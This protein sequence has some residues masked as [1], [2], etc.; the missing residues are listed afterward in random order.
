MFEKGTSIIQGGTVV[1][2]DRLAPAHDVVIVDGR[3]S[4]IEPSRVRPLMPDIKLIDATGCYVAP[5]F[6]DIH[7]DYIEGIASPRPSVVMDLRG[8]LYEADRS[9]AAYGVT[10]IYHSLSIYK[11]LVFDHKPIRRFSNVSALIE[12]IDQMRAG[13][14]RDHLIRHRLHVRV[15]LDAVDHFQDVEDLLHAGKVDLISFMDHT[16]GQGQ[17]RDL[18]VFAKTIKSYKGNLSDE[19]VQGMVDKQQAAAKLDLDQIAHLTRIAHERGV[20]VA[21]HDDDSTEEVAFMAGLGASISEF[22]ISLEVA[23]RARDLGMHTIAGAPNVLLGYSHSGNLSARES[24]CAGA[25]DILCSDYYPA[26]LL[27]AVF[28]LHQSCDISLPQAFALVTLNPARAVGI[29]GEVG[30]IAEGMRAD[31]LL[32]RELSLDKGSPGIPVVEEVFVEGRSVFKTQYPQAIKQ[33]AS[34]GSETGLEEAHGA[35]AKPPV[36]SVAPVATAKSPVP[37][38]APVAT[39]S[40]EAALESAVGQV[41]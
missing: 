27:R 24:V 12:H 28:E 5:G 20:S 8:A 23:H 6:I 18:E 2:A 29:E 25:T 16:P 11:M 26:A 21:S 34:S 1:L 17:Y 37:S 4:A 39:A 9:L 13:E 38:V 41:A 30:Q 35:T 40:Q 10:T 33:A 31:I 36:P 15:E 32:V 22:P 3:I 14:L 7:S 19:E